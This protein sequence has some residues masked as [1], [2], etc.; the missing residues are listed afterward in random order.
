MTVETPPR[1]MTADELLA[2]PDDG[3]RH[4]L[5]Q[6]E[7]IAMSPAGAEHGE[8]AARLHVSLGSHVRRLKLGETFIADTGF[9]LSRGPDTVRAPD[10]SFVRSERLVGT[11]HFFPGAPDVAIEVTSPSDTYTEVDE[12]VAAYIAAGARMVI[13]VNPRA[14]T[15]TVTTPTGTQRLTIDDTLEGGDVVPDWSLPLR[16]LFE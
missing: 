1:L 13:V 12:K 3:I 9:W 15:A 2:M 14:H 11:E 7:L 4:E 5:V 8:V 16:E 6:G 10:V